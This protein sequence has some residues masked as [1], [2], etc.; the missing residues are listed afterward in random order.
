MINPNTYNSL[1]GLT[2]QQSWQDLVLWEWFLNRAEAKSVLELGTGSGAFS[3]F[4]LTQCLSR[5]MQFATIDHRPF[6][7]MALHHQLGL[8]SLFFQVDLLKPGAK[9]QVERIMYGFPRP[10]VLYC[11]NGDKPYEVALFH[12]LLKTGDY[13]GVHDF[14]IE[15]HDHDLAPIQDRIVEIVKPEEAIGNTRWYR[16]YK[17]KK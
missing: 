7:E 5:G 2:M 12:D 8:K 14:G 11:D 16:L 10:I 9:A 13:L 3:C 1:Y 6:Q 17:G 4:L 15:F